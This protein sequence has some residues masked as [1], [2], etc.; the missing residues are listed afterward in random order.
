MPVT[1][2]PAGTHTANPLTPANPLVPYNPRKRRDDSEE[3]ELDRERMR[4][5][6]RLVKREEEKGQ[7]VDVRVRE[8]TRSEHRASDVLRLCLLARLATKRAPLQR[9]LN[10]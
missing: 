9:L 1:I 6:K 10:G 2:P 8:T 5:K 3:H 7:K 4:R